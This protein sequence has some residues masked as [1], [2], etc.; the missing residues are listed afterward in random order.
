MSPARQAQASAQA[1]APAHAAGSTR[2]RIVVEALR[3]FA[4]NGYAGTSVRDI[5]QAVGIKAASL[6]KHFSSKQDIFDGVIAYMDE[7][8]GGLARQA[9]LPGGGVP[10]AGGLQ[11]EGMLQAARQYASLSLEA[12]VAM[13]R[14]LFD[15]ATRDECQVLYRRMLTLGQYADER[16]ARI[17]RQVNFEAPLAYQEALFSRMIEEGALAPDDPRELA[18][19]FYGPLYLLIC[20]Y[21]ATQNP[22]LLDRALAH[23]ERFARAHEVRPRPVA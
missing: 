6:Y 22:A 18:I 17:N 13:A 16:V 2:E 8:Y 19:E 3:L 21:D 23:V 5:A 10:D 14:A 11:G 7:R 15:Y 12:L 1:R 4:A 9:G 20:E